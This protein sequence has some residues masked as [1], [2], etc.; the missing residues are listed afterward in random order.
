[1]DRDVET[2]RGRGMEETGM[3]NG[4]DGEGRAGARRG[5][6]GKCTIGDGYLKVSTCISLLY[7]VWIDGTDRNH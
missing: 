7:R 4:G 1:M 2:R 6:D 3:S 5:Q